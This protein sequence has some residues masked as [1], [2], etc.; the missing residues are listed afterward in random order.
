MFFIIIL[1]CLFRLVALFSCLDNIAVMFITGCSRE[2]IPP[3]SLRG[4]LEEYFTTF[5]H[6]RLR[7]S[8]NF[9]HRRS[10]CLELCCVAGCNSGELYQVS[11][12]LVLQWRKVSFHWKASKEAPWALLTYLASGQEVL[13][14]LQH[15][16]I[17]DLC[18]FREELQ[19]W[20][21]WLFWE[22]ISSVE[23]PFFHS[24]DI[25][26]K[27]C[28]FLYQLQPYLLIFFAA[29]YHQPQGCNLHWH[30]VCI[31]RKPSWVVLES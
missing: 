26:E 3:L 23:E 11:S 19:G 20:L 30:I 18:Y 21:Q 13:I 29:A 22:V 10:F 9:L 8:Y 15:S 1:I 31:F 14:P 16:F 27:S 5:P 4:L 25:L 12:E 17:P 2:G 28:R 6:S 7:P 24:K